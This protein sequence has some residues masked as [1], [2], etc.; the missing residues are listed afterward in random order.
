MK[1]FEMLLPET[2]E[3]A[4]AALDERPVEPANEQKTR[5]LAGGQDLL[6]ELKDRAADNLPSRLVA[7]SGVFSQRERSCSLSTARACSRLICTY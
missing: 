7:S 1:D 3:E 6:T 4:V 2:L 5:I